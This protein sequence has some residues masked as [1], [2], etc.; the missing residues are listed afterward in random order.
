MSKFATAQIRNVCLL[1]HGGS[2][3][4]SLAE[5]ILYLTKAT[6]RLGKPAEGNTVCDFDPEEIKRGFSIQSAI[7]P[8]VWKGVKINILDTPGY[9]D[10]AGEVKQSIRV[11]DAALIVIDGKAGLEVGAELAWEYATE[12]GLPRSIFIN[13]FD[14]PECRFNKVF[15]QLNEAFGKSI[16]PLLIPLVEAGAVVG[17]INLIDLKTYVYNKQGT[18]EEGTIPPEYND[19]VEKYRDLL[20]EAVAETS[21]ELM[22]K[23]FAG[24]EITRE[25]AVEA[26]HQ[27]IIHGTICPVICGSAGKMWGVEAL[28]DTIEESYPRHTAKKVEINEEGD[29]VA[30]D[31][32]AAEPA[33]FVF[34]TVADSFGKQTF[35]KVMTGNLDNTMVLKNLRTGATEKFG[36]IYEVRGKKTVEVDSLACGDI[37]MIQKLNDTAT[38]D[39]LTNLDLKPYKATEYPEAYMTMAI[40]PK[41]KGDEDKIATGI[42]RL[43]DEDKTIGFENNAETKQLLISGLGDIHLDIVTNRLKARN[44]VEVELSKPKIAY[45]ETIKKRVQVEGKHKKQSG[46]HGQYG[47]VRITFAPGEAEGLTF[48][49]SV[50]GGAVP[51]NFFPAVEKGLLEAMQKGILAG[52]PVVNLAA[53]LY[54]GSYHDV[55]SSEMAFKLAANL[56][57]KELVNASPVLLEPVGE[58]KVTVPDDIVGDVI[59]DLNKRRGRVLGM[60]H[61]AGKKG[62]Q[63]LVAEVPQSEMTDYPIALRAM[64]QGKGVFSYAFVRY[65]EVPANIAQKV[66]AESKV[67]E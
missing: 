23:Y 49:E 2:G 61:I 13:K 27:G 25:E 3:K 42:A 24:E 33:I 1:G 28:L 5:A 30:I 15:D 36:H 56:A 14:D 26:I 57:F 63:I 29:D 18:H 50:V 32:E 62:Y 12:A 4:T 39:T 58:L 54:D 65:E 17:F 35:F 52:Y 9:L 44:N 41:S 43:R 37:G 67:E 20:L 60:E 53:D 46:G 31:K 11:A 34:K 51:K 10:F 66:I 6:D 7:A 8:A 45:R 19:V 48:T 21:D 55:D 40:R 64:S 16:C 22:E 59:G 47:H 38:N